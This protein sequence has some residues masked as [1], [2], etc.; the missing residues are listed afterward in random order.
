MAD[1]I[2]D[3]AILKPYKLLYLWTSPD[4]PRN[5]LYTCSG[6]LY[7]AKTRG[8]ALKLAPRI[9]V[10][11]QKPSEVYRPCQQAANLSNIL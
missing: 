5:V 11:F 3:V 8:I 6:D 10:T 2:T 4:V 7:T 1:R 9:H